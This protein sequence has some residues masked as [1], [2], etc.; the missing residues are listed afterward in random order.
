MPGVVVE[1]P[2]HGFLESDFLNHSDGARIIVTRSAIPCPVCGRGAAVVDGD[3]TSD[4]EGNLRATLW[5]TR[6]QDLRLRAALIRAKQRQVRGASDEEAA[7]QLEDSLVEAVPQAKSV[8]DAFK[9]ERGMATATWLGVLISLV[10]VF[11]TLTSDNGISEQ[12]LERILDE[13]VRS[14]QS[15]QSRTE[16]QDPSTSAERQQPRVQPPVV[17]DLPTPETH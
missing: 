9:G 13:T 12:D 15:E 4:G 11:L 7:Q 10:T 2:E 17:F 6:E 8:L 5:L 3:Y 1:C 16:P 14:V